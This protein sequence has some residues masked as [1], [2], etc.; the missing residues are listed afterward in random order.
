M[1]DIDS[2]ELSFSPE[3]PTSYPERP[4]TPKTPTG[5][6]PRTD[7]LAE[8]SDPATREEA[9][10]RELHGVR[11]INELL[12]GVI[13]TLERAKGNMG[14]VSQTVNTASTLL[15]TWTKILSQTEHNQKL[16]LNP[17]W[18]GASEDLREIE[19]E[20]RLRQA[21]LERRAMEEERRRTE[22]ERKRAEEERRRETP[23]SAAPGTR[24]TVRGTRS[25]EHN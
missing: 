19:N 18:K 7:P 11:N 21:A 6:P 17:D 1:S 12:E 13:G 14:T 2:S 24:G 5:P 20:E 15:N 10:E 22:A 25:Y 4:K 8:P 16:I 9:L 3:K 23:S